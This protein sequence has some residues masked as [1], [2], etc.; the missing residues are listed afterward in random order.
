MHKIK[1]FLFLGVQGSNNFGPIL[2]ISLNVY[3]V[4]YAEKDLLI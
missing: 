1:L 3:K 2:I 4:Q